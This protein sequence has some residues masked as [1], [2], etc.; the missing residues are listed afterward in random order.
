[1]Q[2][3]F[4]VVAEISKATGMGVLIVEQDVAAALKIATRIAIFQSGA[5]VAEYSRQDCPPPTELWRYF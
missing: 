1:M 5:V 3:I 4:S 2:R